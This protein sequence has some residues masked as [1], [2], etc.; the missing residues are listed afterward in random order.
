MV[1]FIASSV[2]FCLIQRDFTTINILRREP[3][4]VVFSKHII[5]KI[6]PKLRNVEIRKK[7]VP[8]KLP[9]FVALR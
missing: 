7:N 9:F 1:L 6:R 3:F 2:F 5:E 8:R 4:F